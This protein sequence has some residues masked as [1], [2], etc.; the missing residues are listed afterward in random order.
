MSSLISMEQHWQGVTRVENTFRVIILN[1]TNHFWQRNIFFKIFDF[2]PTCLE[3]T[4]NQTHWYIYTWVLFSTHVWIITHMSRKKHTWVKKATQLC[5][6]KC[7]VFSTYVWKQPLTCLFSPELS[8]GGHRPALR[9]VVPDPHEGKC[10]H[11][12]NAV[13]RCRLPSSSYWWH[14]MKL[15]S[16]A[17]LWKICIIS[18]V[19]N[20]STHLWHRCC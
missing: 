10:P 20:V 9:Q 1:H 8:V 14:W 16:Y 5:I 17:M 11:A 3:K 7:W 12:L 4:K 15:A 6:C 19:I 13:S 2:Y 18:L